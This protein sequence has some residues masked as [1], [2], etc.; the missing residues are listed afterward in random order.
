[1]SSAFFGGSFDPPHCGH[2]AVAR[3]ALS[4]GVC[5]LVRWVVGAR[6]PHKLTQER[7]PFADRLKM[8]ELLIEGEK[9]MAASDL[10]LRMDSAKAS[11]TIDALKLYEKVYGE[12]P[13]LLIG[14]DSLLALHTWRE[15]E[16]LVDNYTIVTYP[17]RGFE[18]DLEKLRR[19]WQNQ[20][21]EKLLR[22]VLPGEL[23][24]AASCELRKLIVSG[25]NLPLTENVKK[26]IV[27]KQL[28]KGEKYE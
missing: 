23:V 17:R 15:A 6:P 18:V 21:A 1:M 2:L 16:K 27:E 12:S 13:I 24:D 8:V 20:E 26:Y 4:S 9:G 14:A 22:G 19:N 10:E 7:T 5:E 11:Y 28:Y 3:A 25:G